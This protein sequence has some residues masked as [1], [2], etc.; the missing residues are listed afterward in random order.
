MGASKL[1]ILCKALREIASSDL[2]LMKS[3]PEMHLVWAIMLLD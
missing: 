3:L 1:T 2:G